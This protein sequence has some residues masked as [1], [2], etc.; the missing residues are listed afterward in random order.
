MNWYCLFVYSGKEEYIVKC[1]RLHF[2]ESIMTLLI[3]KRKLKERKSGKTHHVLK[4]MF[5]GYILIRTQMSSEINH[6]INSIPNVISM[7]NTG[8][9]Y[10]KIP[11]EELKYILHLLGGGDIVDFSKVCLVNSKVV[12]K[13]GP[14]LGLE[15]LI[16]KVDR[17]KSRVKILLPF[18][19]LRQEIDV[20]IEVVESKI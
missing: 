18:M 11:D 6:T 19:G 14:L 15:D 20:G 1:L 12:V 8:D 13:S 17:R 5:P 9:V 16:Q 2:D 10:T 7:L 4:K 3:P